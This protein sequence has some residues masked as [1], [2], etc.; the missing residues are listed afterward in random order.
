MAMVTRS[1]R[2]ARPTSRENPMDNIGP[3][4]YPLPTS[5]KEASDLRPSYAPFNSSKDLG[6]FSTQDS[7]KR[8]KEPEPWPEPGSYNPKYPKAYDSGLPK[9]HVPFSCGAARDPP[10][11]KKAAMPGPG[12]YHSSSQQLEI[13]ACKTMG[14]PIATQKL[15]VKST[16]APSIPRDNQCFG[17]DEAGDGRLVR[18]SRKDGI[19]TL[20]GKGA[21]SA[22]PGHYPVH[23]VDSMASNKAVFGRILP[24]KQQR[25]MSVPAETPGPGHYVPQGAFNDK[26]IYSSFASQTERGSKIAEKRAAET[27][28]PGE[29]QGPR[30]TRPNLREQHA[31]LQFFGSTAERFPQEASKKQPGPGAYGAPVYKNRSKASIPSGWSTSDRFSAQGGMISKSDGPGPGAYGAPGSRTEHGAGSVSILG[32]TGSLA[33]GSMESRKG[34]ASKSGNPGPGHYVVPS[35]SDE[36]SMYSDPPSG[37]SGGNGSSGARR[38]AP[39]GKFKQ[40]SSFFQNTV[41]KDAMTRSYE[42]SGQRGPPPGAYNPA[43]SRD[44]GTV[45]RMPPKG[46]GFGSAALRSGNDVKAVTAPGPGW[47]KPGDVT[48]GKVHGTHNRA[49]VEGVPASGRQKAF[50]FDSQTSRFRKLADGKVCPGPGAYN[51][52]KSLITATYNINFGDFA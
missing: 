49:A 13:S 30:P 24:P 34:M 42:K 26:P 50:G 27:P 20:T 22:G 5:F 28:G 29:Y 40:P 43:H 12:E 7:P 1:D 2:F 46:E 15:M 47:Y 45:M 18:Q 37:T 11:I 3:G 51:P 25:S 39:R 41:P 32:A 14:A 35:M 17:Y 4:Q 16:S 31:E 48:G 52:E 10:K 38:M 19:M 44:V 23:E 33:F 8:R 6:E 36:A 9:K 21:D